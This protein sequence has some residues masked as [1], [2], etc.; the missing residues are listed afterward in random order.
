MSAA[1]PVF[2]ALRASSSQDRKVFDMFDHFGEYKGDYLIPNP[3]PDPSE[4][5][6][7]K[8]STLSCRQIAIVTLLFILMLIILY[9]VETAA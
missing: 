5:E 1:I 2:A 7:K 4:D 8:K 9:V 3:P 6:N